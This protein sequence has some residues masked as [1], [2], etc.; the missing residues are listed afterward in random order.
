MADNFKDNDVSRVRDTLRRIESELRKASNS[1]ERQF[2]VPDDYD[3]YDKKSA[4]IY[5]KGA[6]RAILSLFE[7]LD[8]Q[9]LLSEA[10]KD[11]SNFQKNPLDSEMGPEEPYLIWDQ[12]ALEY[13]SVLE[14]IYPEME[15]GKT[16]IQTKELIGILERC[17]LYV[18]SPT[19]FSWKPIDEQDI[20]ERIEQ[21]LKCVYPDLKT[22]PTISKP[23]KGFK[24]DTGITSL[25]TLIEYKYIVCQ[26]DAKRIVDELLA[27]L[28]GYH[29]H[30]YKKYIFVIYETE[31]IRTRE[32]WNDLISAS[33]PASPTSVVLLKGTS[34]T[35]LDRE[36]AEKHR[37]QRKKK[38][39]IKPK[40][41]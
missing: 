6:W 10:L 34:P 36:I 21:L 31:R 24:P 3:K 20:H 25:K 40:A 30:E 8:H 1:W 17:E 11:Y 9:V 12:K 35:E 2:Y 22:N 19:L 27:D 16:D 18:I 26:E 15:N 38:K 5:L 33:T 23:I 29:G 39:P 4:E 28:G 41:K 14:T 13:I 32:E 7:I 37:M